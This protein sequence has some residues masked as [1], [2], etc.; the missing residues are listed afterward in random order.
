MQ[1]RFGGLASAEI[2]RHGPERGAPRNGSRQGE[3]G[4][5]GRGW[6]GRA[7]GEP[8]EKPARTGVQSVGGRG[9]R[10]LTGRVTVLL[11]N[12]PCAIHSGVVGLSTR[13]VFVR[14]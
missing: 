5:R 14:R 3:T 6:S 13:S 4:R 12:R 11:M 7:L 8:K 2:G 10:F 1:R 9:T